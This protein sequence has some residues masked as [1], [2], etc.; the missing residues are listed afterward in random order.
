MFIILL[1]I[2]L[3]HN[4]RI[5]EEDMAPN[6]VA[7]RS[8]PVLLH[9]VEKDQL[10]FP[11]GYDVFSGMDFDKSKDY[12]HIMPHEEPHA[13]RRR[14]ILAKYPKIKE[15]YVKDITSAWITISAV[16]F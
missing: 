6:F 2:L 4:Q 16:V 11:K 13:A 3:K 15:L 7:D 5:V 10:D 1:K 14:A 12:F 8:T 9:S